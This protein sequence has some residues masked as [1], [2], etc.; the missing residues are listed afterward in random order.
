MSEPKCECKGPGFC[1]RY[2]IQQQEYHYNLCSCTP[3]E[4]FVITPEKSERYR[5]KWREDLAKKSEGGP[6]LA[7]RAVNVT[8]AL[9]RAVEAGF[10]KVSLEVLQKRQSICESNVCGFKGD[11]VCLNPQCGCPL[12]AKRVLIGILERPGKLEWAS[13]RCPAGFWEA[14]S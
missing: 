6:G 3:M 1:Q 11:N 7:Q 8:K 14:E 13:E 5:K 10:K 2:Q 12:V 9:G 4:G